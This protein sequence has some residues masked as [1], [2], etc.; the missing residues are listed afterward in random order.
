MYIVTLVYFI[1]VFG[2][3]TK[4]DINLRKYRIILTEREA[5]KF[6]SRYCQFHKKMPE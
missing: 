4:E 1:F 2:Y 5:H 6:S 3:N